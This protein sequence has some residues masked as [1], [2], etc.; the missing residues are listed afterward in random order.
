MNVKRVSYFSFLIAISAIATVSCVHAGQTVKTASAPSRLITTCELQGITLECWMALAK[1]LE[2]KGLHPGQFKI[3][4]Y[5]LSAADEYQVCIELNKC[6]KGQVNAFVNEVPRPQLYDR[7]P[8]LA[9]SH[10]G[11]LYPT[12][13][14]AALKQKSR[15]LLE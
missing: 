8:V 7:S 10:P 9:L 1:T 4:S 3:T 14:R 5:Q 15:I 12:D 11:F 13:L 6:F 2:S